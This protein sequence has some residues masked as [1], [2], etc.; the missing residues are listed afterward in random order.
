MGKMP[1]IKEENNSHML[2]DAMDELEVQDE[3]LFQGALLSTSGIDK[4]KSLSYHWLNCRENVMLVVGWVGTLLP[5]LRCNPPLLFLFCPF[6]VT[7]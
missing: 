7:C 2:W 1:Q 4:I 3:R 5:C 6:L